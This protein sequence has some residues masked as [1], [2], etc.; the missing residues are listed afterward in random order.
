MD[1]KSL[2]CKRCVNKCDDAFTK[3]AEGCRGK[4]PPYAPTIEEKIV[5]LTNGSCPD[6]YTNVAR[7]CGA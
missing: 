5:G 2:N 1:D 6:A 7:Y 4:I 3:K